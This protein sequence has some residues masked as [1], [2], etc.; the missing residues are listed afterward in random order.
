MSFRIGT[1]VV[2]AIYIGT[3][4]I[5]KAYVGETLLLDVTYIATQGADIITTQD[6]DEL[7]TQSSTTY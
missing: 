3:T 6:T 4:R 1:T 5:A 2:D 7:V